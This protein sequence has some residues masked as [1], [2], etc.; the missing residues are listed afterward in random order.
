[1]KRCKNCDIQYDEDISFCKVCG[2]ELEQDSSVDESTE[3]NEVNNENAE[4]N[5]ETTNEETFREEIKLESYAPEE[6]FEEKYSILNLV[7]GMFSR[8][9]ETMKGITEKLNSGTAWILLGIIS[10]IN[11]L[12]S[13]GM[14]RVV[15]NRLVASLNATTAGEGMLYGGMPYGFS[16]LANQIQNSKILSGGSIFCISLVSMIIFALLI[17]LCIYIMCKIFRSKNTY[18]DIFKIVT[19]S[20]VYY[21]VG[22]LILL[23]LILINSN[24]VFMVAI[25][26]TLMVAF[27]VSITLGLV[28]SL[29]VNKDRI[30]Y[31]VSLGYMLNVIINNYLLEFIMNLF[32]RNAFMNGML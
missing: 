16:G 5:T 19:S 20:L 31:I 4:V 11:S 12:F 3:K 24:F 23:L 14:V 10:I 15:I 1:M 30:I 25:L 32:L 27:F 6:N 8:P 7:K 17:T 28:N 13:V 26:A 29:R 18:M 2:K 22:Y 9:F 21:T